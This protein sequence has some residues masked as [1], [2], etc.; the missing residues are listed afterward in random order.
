MLQLM[1]MLEPGRSITQHLTD[2]KRNLRGSKKKTLS[3]DAD[4]AVIYLWM[5]CTCI[6]NSGR[7]GASKKRDKNLKLRE[8][9]EG[10]RERREEGE[11]GGHD[12]LSLFLPAE[13]REERERRCPGH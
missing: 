8:K 11:G 2:K 13:N 4:A 6:T 10:E 3:T 7:A 12:P 9:D 1:L 5:M